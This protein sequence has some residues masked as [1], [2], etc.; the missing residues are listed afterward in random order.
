MDN[1]NKQSWIEKL[2]L[3]S[4]NK[5]LPTSQPTSAPQ[6]NSKSNA[7]HQAMAPK[8]Q[9]TQQQSNIHKKSTANCNLKSEMQQH[10]L[11]ALEH[12]KNGEIA[13]RA[14]ANNH[15]QAY[16]RVQ[17]ALMLLD[18]LNYLYEDKLNNLSQEYQQDID[19]IINCYKQE[20]SQFEEI[21]YLQKLEINKITQQLHALQATNYTNNNNSSMNEPAD[22]NANSAAET[23]APSAI[24]MEERSIEN[25]QAKPSLAVKSSTSDTPKRKF[26]NFFDEAFYVKKTKFGTKKN[27]IQKDL[28]EDNE[29]FFSY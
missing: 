11:I 23:Q 4:I 24:G 28:Y 18:K 27:D 19:E 16:E 2:G 9:E 13:R 22:A 29:D 3:A 20:K 17:E 7:N 25:T 8:N 5:K 14:L 10:I 12:I 26:M 6:S 21:I 15:E 1:P